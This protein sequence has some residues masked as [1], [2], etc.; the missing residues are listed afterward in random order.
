MDVP[1]EQTKKK[2][3]VKPECLVFVGYDFEGKRLTE[4]AI[5]MLQVREDLLD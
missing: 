5:T 2:D 1:Q 4:A 3:T